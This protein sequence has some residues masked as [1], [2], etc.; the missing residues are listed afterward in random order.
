MAKLHMYQELVDKI[1]EYKSER[2]MLQARI[3]ELITIIEH[4]KSIS[5]RYERIN[6]QMLKN[7]IA[8]ERLSDEQREKLQNILVISE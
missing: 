5:E 6:I 7:F 4:Y 3:D 2:K 8:N 1:E